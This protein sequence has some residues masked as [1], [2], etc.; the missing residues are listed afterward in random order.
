MP[1]LEDIHPVPA[2]DPSRSHSIAMT[3][4]LLDHSEDMTDCNIIH[5]SKIEVSNSAHGLCVLVSG[6]RKFSS[7]IAWTC[8]GHVETHRT[9][10][11]YKKVYGPVVLTQLSSRNNGTHSM[12][13][14]SDSLDN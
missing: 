11:F 5:G 10:T 4:F 6:D 12:S 3:G 13:H 2:T 7:V 8:N 1:I 14:D 9:P